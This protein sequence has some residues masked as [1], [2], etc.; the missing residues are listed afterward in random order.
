MTDQQWNKKIREMVDHSRVP[1]PEDYDD[2]VQNVLDKLPEQKAVS[3]KRF[4]LGKRTKSAGMI[5]RPIFAGF[6]LVVLMAG[7]SVGAV[8]HG[9][10]QR[11][12]SMNA[13]QRKGYVMDIAET[14]VDGD[15]Y[16]RKLTSKEQKRKEKLTAEY[17]A[18]ECY[19]ERELL[20]VESEVQIQADKVCFLPSTSIF[21]LPERTLT[22]EELLE[23]I[24]F[25]YKRDFS[26]AQSYAE[27]SEKSEEQEAE[28]ADII[29]EEEA[30]RLAQELIRKI[31]GVD[32][33]TWTTEAE[34]VEIPHNKHMFYGIDFW[35]QQTD[36][37]YYLSIGGDGKMSQFLCGTIEENCVDGFSISEKKIE[38]IYPKVLQV[39]KVLSPDTG[40]S[41]VSCAY[42]RKADGDLPNGAVQFIFRQGNNRGWVISY[43]LQS[44]RCYDI[45]FISDLKLDKE[46]NEK[47]AK[48][49]HAERHVV[50]LKRGNV[51]KKGGY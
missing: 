46:L 37:S 10:L 23:L 42:Y 3:R 35:E 47:N 49:Y 39:F 19:P 51:V 41:K 2:Y 18:G 40:F 45:S 29:S 43:S 33:S 22:D 48:K 4:L 11:M 5:L 14:T 26:L 50:T 44:K 32:V 27:D 12:E 13:S 36:A 28:K 16:T 9:Y 6:C 30:V 34:L 15:R 1:Y 17:E 20:I 24:D 21:Y 7:V 38:K 8:V 25:Y 31:H